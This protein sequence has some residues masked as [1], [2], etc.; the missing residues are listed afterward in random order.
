MKQILVYDERY[1]EI[2]THEI[3][4]PLDKRQPR[5][6]SLLT[7]TAGFQG[8]ILCEVFTYLI[9]D[10]HLFDRCSDSHSLYNFVF[11]N[12]FCC[13]FLFV[14]TFLW[15]FLSSRELSQGFYYLFLII[16]LLRLYAARYRSPSGMFHP[17]M[18]LRMLCWGLLAF[19]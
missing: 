11:N 18:R 19:E 15:C 1:S 8:N 2:L 12:R 3:R 4:R 13:C 6:G 16:F 9:K 14:R 7:A 17:R 10:V 5:I